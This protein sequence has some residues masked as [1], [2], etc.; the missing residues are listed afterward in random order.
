MD[1]IFSEEQL[2]QA[3]EENNTLFLLKHST[4]CPISQ[5]A[6]E[7]YEKFSKEENVPCYYLYVQEARPLSNYVAEQYN[8]KHESPQVLY[9]KQGN[10]E[11]NTSHFDITYEKLSSYLHE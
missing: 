1:K 9:F 3:L 10:V 8:V 7:Q 2:N 11:G 5:N 6:F 4:T